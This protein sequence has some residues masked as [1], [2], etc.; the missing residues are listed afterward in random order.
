MIIINYDIIIYYDDQNCVD[1]S[2]LKYDS[3]SL[4]E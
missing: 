3:N 2:K 1:E 4:L